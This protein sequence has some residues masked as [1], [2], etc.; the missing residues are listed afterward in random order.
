MMTKE[1]I[2]GYIKELL[3]ISRDSDN[4]CATIRVAPKKKAKIK[5]NIERQQLL[6]KKLIKII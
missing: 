2:H 5:K 1:D 4:L 3:I 6:L